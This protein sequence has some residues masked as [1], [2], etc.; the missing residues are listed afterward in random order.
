MKFNEVTG[1]HQRAFFICAISLVT[2]G[3]L[4]LVF[5]VFSQCFLPGIVNQQIGDKLVVSSFQSASYDDFV[6]N[7][8][9]NA[10]AKL[11][12]LYLFHVTNPVDFLNSTTMPIFEQRGPYVF[13][14]RF[15]HKNVGITIYHV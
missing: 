15:Y 4:S 11:N 12:K 5:T 3:F 8:N 14:E 10:P 6:T 7:N 9:V 13:R 2:L 1:F